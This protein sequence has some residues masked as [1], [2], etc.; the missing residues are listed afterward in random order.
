MSTTLGIGLVGAGFVGSVH[1]QAWR[2]APHFFDLAVA[3]RMRV[4]CDTALRRAAWDAGQYGRAE[5][6][7]AFHSLLARPDVD[8]VD[9]CVPGRLHA[10]VAIAVL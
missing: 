3:P 10:E 5:H 6:A 9:I 8:L 2:V 7:P 1:S 4:L